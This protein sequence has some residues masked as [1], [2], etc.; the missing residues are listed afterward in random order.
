MKK[1]IAYWLYLHQNKEQW[2]TAR[3]FLHYSV[4]N[5]TSGINEHTPLAQTTKSQTEP[6]PK[7]IIL[8]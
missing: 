1:K 5:S 7:A 4:K 6:K 8:K 2:D 3:L